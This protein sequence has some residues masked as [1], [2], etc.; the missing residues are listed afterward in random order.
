MNQVEAIRSFLA[1]EIPL[2]QRMRLAEE[3]QALRRSLPSARWVRPDG[4]HLTL[5]FLGEVARDRLGSL[6]SDCRTRLATAAPV[7]VTLAGSG[8][9]PG[10]TRPRV[11]W[12]GGTAEPIA[13]LVEAVESAAERQGLPRE[14][15]RWAVHLTLARLREPWP[16]G[17]VRSYL[18]WGERLTLEPF[19]CVE[20][21]LFAS[22]LEPTGA[23]YTALER[24][25]L[26]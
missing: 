22:S 25:P 6:A 15:R 14:R 9:F 24:M 16:A 11:A 5:K 18:E 3:Q 8:F 23:V 20:V 12:V 4:L 13:A 17:A 7:R 19:T 1:L 21:V 2:A 26:S 10:P